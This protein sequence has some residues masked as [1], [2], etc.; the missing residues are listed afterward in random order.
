MW[1]IWAGNIYRILVGSLKEQEHLL[2]QESV[3]DGSII[4]KLTLK[5][6]NGKART[7]LGSGYRT[8]LGR[9]NTV[10]NLQVP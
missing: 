7:G 3:T 10:M 9:V 1:Q 8:V 2:T 5:I 6:Q 4:L